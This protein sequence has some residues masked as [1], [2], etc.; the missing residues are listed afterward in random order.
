MEEKEEGGLMDTASLS[1]E[2]NARHKVSHYLSQALADTYVLYVKTQNF[3]WN[4]QDP[5]FYS[6]HKFFEEQYEALAE[7][8]DDIAERIRALQFKAPGSMK[9][10]L[11][12]TNLAEG[13]NDLSANAMIQQ[14]IEDH[15]TIANQIRPWIPDSQKLKDEATA[16]LFIERLRFHEK[17]A[18]MLRS[19][20]AHQES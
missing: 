14:L 9:Q 7:A 8:T 18:W 2:R 11:E 6:L 3:H 10:F 15:E 16:D 5:R 19:H 12:I 1:L 20:F 4:V 17:S 13:E